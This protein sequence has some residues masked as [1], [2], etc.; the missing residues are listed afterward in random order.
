MTK[1]AIICVGLVLVGALP[2]FADDGNGS[3][4]TVNYFT[5]AQKVTAFG[6]STKAGYTP[7]IVEAF[8]DGNFFLRADK[9]GERFE[10][11]VVR[12]G[13]VYPSTPLTPMS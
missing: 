6:A 11:T 13:Q 9:G 1:F 10:V 12:S 3:P 2:A 4:G 8:Q 5:P 7:T